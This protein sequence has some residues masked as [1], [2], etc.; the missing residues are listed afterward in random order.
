MTRPLISVVVPSYNH[1]RFLPQRLDSIFAQ[2]FRDFEVIVLDDC[3]TDDSKKVLEEYA[4]RFP[5]RLD[6]SS[7]N[8]GSPF[9]Q[10]KRGAE[11]SEGKFL[12]IAESDDY[13]DPRLLETL[14][15]AFQKNSTVGLAYCQ[16]FRVDENNQKLGTME[17]WTH[18]LHQ[19]RWDSDYFNRGRDEVARYLIKRNTIPNASAVL[20]R[21]DLFR[22][23]L[24]GSATLRLM[25]DWWTWTRVLANSDIAFIAEPLNFFRMHKASVRDSTKRF[26]ACAEALHVV[27]HM[28][29][30]F[31]I[32]SS[33]R[34]HVVAREFHGIWAYLESSGN[35][36][37]CE[38]LNRV[39]HDATAIHWSSH[40]RLP[41]LKFKQNLKRLPL[42]HAIA[43]RFVRIIKNQA[44]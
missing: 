7:K 18:D 11:L 24:E 33:H 20:V 6:F 42:F 12:W 30:R 43:R 23:A 21:A 31:P 19:T 15:S 40:L 39:M 37:N 2:T 8:S 35:V 26:I 38:W 14:T 9:I 13:A 36:S 44:L 41:F 32:S 3:S 34:R 1:A 28:C 5:M 27:A 25:G 4:R 16:S 22:N 29:S 17:Y 10:W